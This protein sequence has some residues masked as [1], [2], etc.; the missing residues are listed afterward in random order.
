LRGKK[1]RTGIEM[2]KIFW[3]IS[4]TIHN[5]ENYITFEV[6]VSL[7]YVN[8]CEIET[9]VSHL[10]I[11]PYSRLHVSVDSGVL[12]VIYL[13]LRALFIFNNLV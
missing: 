2:V 5:L 7:L 9:E 10:T 1:L 11:L 6:P 4:P 3:T 13:T 8:C 12:R